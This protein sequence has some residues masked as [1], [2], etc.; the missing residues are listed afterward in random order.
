MFLGKTLC[1]FEWPAQEEITMP[2]YIVKV[3]LS[4]C[5]SP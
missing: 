2:A 5:S 3:K 1:R 4:L